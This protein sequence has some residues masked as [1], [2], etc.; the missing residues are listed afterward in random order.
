MKTTLSLPRVALVALALG[1]ASVTATFAQ[2]DTNTATPP[3]SPSG[4]GHH[5]H[6]RNSVLTAAEK[7]EL[8]TAR[9]QAFAAN[10]SLKTDADNLHQQFKT[11]RSEGKGVATK[12]Q[13]QALHQQKAA[14]RQQLR[15]AELSINPNLAPIFAKLDAS[16]KAWQQQHSSTPAST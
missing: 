12:A 2:T 16:H 6:H 9:E 5:H 15:S 13:W 8:K 7:T 4:G 11:L 14:F 10:G 3:T 1:T